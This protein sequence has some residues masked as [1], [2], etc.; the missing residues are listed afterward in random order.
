MKKLKEESAATA[1]AT[2]PPK[3]IT[4]VEYYQ[5][6][7][8]EKVQYAVSFGIPLGLALEIMGAGG[9]GLL[10]ALIIGLTTGYFSEEVKSGIIDKLP[11]PREQTGTRKR[12]LHWWLTGQQ[13]QEAQPLQEQQSSEEQPEQ[14]SDQVEAPPLSEIDQLF[15]AEQAKEEIVGIQRLHPNDIIRHTEPD[16][17]RIC[18]GRSLT[19]PGNPPVWINFYCQHLKI[20]GASQYGKSSM[21]ACI[22]YLITRTHGP[23]NVLLALLD[24]EH[25]TSKLFTNC[26]HVARVNI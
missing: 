23:E 25:K 12:K 6:T 16:D 21:A 13:T 9:G 19:R 4:A 2:I 7:F 26:D 14:N 10:L 5:M 18:I 20:I 17:Y 3:A 8:V 22:L 11:R 1:P 24:L 15:Q